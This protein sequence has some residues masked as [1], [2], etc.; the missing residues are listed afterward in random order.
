LPLG[1]T[2]DLLIAV[3]DDAVGIAL[4][5]SIYFY[6]KTG[7]PLSGGGLSS[8]GN[9]PLRNMFGEFIRNSHVN[10]GEETPNDVNQYMGFPIA[11]DDPSYPVTNGYR[12]CVNEP[13]DTRVHWDPVGHRFIILGALR[14][15]VWTNYFQTVFD[16]PSYTESQLEQ[17]DYTVKDRF[18]NWI[19]FKCGFYTD[20]NK[21][22]VQLPNTNQCKLARRLLF[23]AVSRTSNP[24]DGFYTYVLL[25]NSHRD[26]PWM[27]T[28]GDWAIF[29]HKNGY[30]SFPVLT[31][32]S[33][34]DMRSG[35][36][37]PQYIPYYS[38]DLSGKTN[39]E[40]PQQDAT[41]PDHSL[42]V[43]VNY[44]AW[45]DWWFF[46]I[47]HPT[48][49]YD[50]Q[51]AIVQ[52]QN[53]PDLSGFTLERTVYRFGAL[54]CTIHIIDVASGK[55]VIRYVKVPLF[56]APALFSFFSLIV[57][58]DSS[59]GYRKW[60]ISSSDPNTLRLDQP[61]LAVNGADEVFLIWSTS[62]V[63]PADQIF[64]RVEHTIWR[65]GATLMD[66]PNVFRA[67]DAYIDGQAIM[68]GFTAAVDPRDDRT[69][70]AVQ[71]YGTPYT[72]RIVM[73]W[74]NPTSNK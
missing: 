67:G 16:H 4:D 49:P 37:Q 15:Y 57:S 13:Y 31:M 14:N 32:V 6:S 58:L 34:A 10:P 52:N 28:D 47:P 44:R 30:D 33:L 2:S 29:T 62:G 72:W 51:A 20:R 38:S 55:S 46:V 11:C 48:V 1:N 12:Y 60:T 74:V 64:P 9:L 27:A 36:R 50:K 3:G 41:L 71:K 42:V 25:D 68:K 26:W 63:R 54:H 5:S 40:P 66:R 65:H 56:L 23:T 24:R 35:K 70:W 22:I 61:I 7:V 59:V 43:H 53:I 45:T 69:F 18:E 39:A 8:N 19:T 21:D 73:G 17:T